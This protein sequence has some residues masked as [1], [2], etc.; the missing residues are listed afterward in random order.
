MI[1]D[2]IGNLK[3]AAIDTDILADEKHGW[4]ALHLF[5][6]P[7]ANGFNHRGQAAARWASKFAFFFDNGRHD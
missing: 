1:D 7:S 2:P 6:D 4:V 3:R 5:P